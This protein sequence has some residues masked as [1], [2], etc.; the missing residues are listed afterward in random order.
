MI[1]SATFSMVD[2]AGISSNSGLR[3]PKKTMYDTLMMYAAVT[4]MPMSERTA[5]TG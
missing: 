3:G 5:I 4:T 1:K 2:T